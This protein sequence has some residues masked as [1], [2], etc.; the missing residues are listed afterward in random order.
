EKLIHIVNNL[1]EQIY[2]FR[3]KYI[4][5]MDSYEGLVRE[6]EEIVESIRIGNRE[7]AEEITI[8]HIENQER[9]VIE[10]LD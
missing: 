7:K 5:Q 9:A 3:V 4:S 1:R 8:R 2:R 10:M 6:H